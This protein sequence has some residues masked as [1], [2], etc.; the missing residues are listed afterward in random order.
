V[1]RICVVGTGYVGLV[2]GTCFAEQGNQVAC[3]DIDETK[4]KLL[5]SGG[6]PIYEP[7]LSELVQRNSAMGRL[8]FTTSYD[9]GMRDAEFVFIAV[10][11]PPLAS[12]GGADLRY[13]EAAAKSIAQHLEHDLIIVNKSTVPIGTGDLVAQ[14]VE[15]ERKTEAQFAVVSNPEFLREGSAVAD[16]LNP[17][18]VVLG[19]TDRAAGEA[20][21]S[22]YLS[23]RCPIIIT[24]LATAEMIKYA[25]NAM[26]AARISFINEMAAI[27][28]ALGADVKQVA[29]GM[30]YDKRIGSS[31]LEAGL[32]YGGSC[33]PKDVKALMHMAL[34]Q[35]CHPQ[36]LQAVEDINND[37]R[38]RAVDKVKELLGPLQG[39]VI[40]LLGLAFKPNTDDMR[41]AASVDIAKMLQAEGAQVKAYDPVSMAVA[42]LF[43]PDVEYCT[44]AY[45]AASGADAVM[46]VTDWNEFKQLDMRRLKGVMRNPVLVDGR[47]IYDGNMLRETGFTYRGTG[48]N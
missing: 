30:G 45:E 34:T 6:M 43:L 32:G 38:R 40:C 11:T 16:C 37:Q 46:V 23:L 28:E 42:R 44:N 21:A 18:R 29:L 26:L 8:C 15:R 41:E 35:G 47:N 10:N 31:F 25:S 2:T 48:R 12:D 7:G 20:V 3:V 1:R 17:D 24:D 27:C 9:E 13:V 5:Q 33:F 22:L 19:A 14:I 36:L 4:I 39:K